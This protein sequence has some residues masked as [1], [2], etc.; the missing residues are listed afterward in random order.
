MK[1]SQHTNGSIADVAPAFWP[2]YQD[3]VVWPSSYVIIPH[4]VYEQY[5]DLGILQE[6]YD[7]MKKWTDYMKGF[8]EDGIMPKNEYGDWCVPPAS[9]TEIHSTDPATK[10]S[11]PL[12][13]TAYFYYDVCLMACAARLLGKTGDAE[14]FDLLAGQLKGAFNRH[15]YRSDSGFYDNGTQTSCVLPLAF[16]LVTDGCRAKVFAHLVSKI[17]NESHNH[18]GTGLVGGQYLMRVLSDNGR[19]DLAYAIATQKTYPSWGYM[20]SK[21]ATTM[22]EL[23]NGDTAAPGMN[24]G[25]H[26]MLVG[27]L[28]IWLHEYLGGIRP[29]PEAPGFKK[30]VIKPEV[31]DGLTWVKASYNSVRGLIV[32][33]WKLNGGKFHLNLT[34]PGNSTATVYVPAKNLAD[35]TEG[36]QLLEQAKGVRFLRLEDSR[37]VLEVGSGQ[38][39]FDSRL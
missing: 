28:N 13:S 19:F 2:F 32:S 29:D 8:L 10:T 14:Q 5:G 6:H 11:G 1:D 20:V 23:W 35:V 17:T 21:G 30:I 36:N 27:D 37:V 34:V 31:A 22:L 16:G 39:A 7:A 18:I 15:F 12:L 38:Y 4:M 25:N 3:G 33:D 24:S 9:L 26:V